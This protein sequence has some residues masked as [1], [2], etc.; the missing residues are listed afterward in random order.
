MYGI[1]QTNLTGTTKCWITRNLGADIQADSANS[2]DETK[3]GWYWQFNRQQGYKHDGITRTPAT[4][5]ITSI[6]ENSDW[7]PANDPCA[8]L[9]GTGWRIPSST[10]WTNADNN[11]GWN[12][13]NDA[14]SSVLKIHAAG[15]LSDGTLNNRGKSGIYWSSIKGSNFVAWI[16]LFNSTTSTT[17]T[18]E[19][20]VGLSLRCIRD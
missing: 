9:L 5:W 20:S 8:I 2:I 10:E 11:G 14:Y 6:D 19:K 13:Y 3:A 7:I 1:V 18:I 15:Y 16:L 12:N 17:G 4:T